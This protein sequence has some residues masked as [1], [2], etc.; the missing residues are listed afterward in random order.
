MTLLTW[1]GATDLDAEQR[2]DLSQSDI[3]VVDRAVTSARMFDGKLMLATD[4]GE[5]A[6]DAI[7]PALG[8]KVSSGIAQGLGDRGDGNDY[9]YVDE[10]QRAEVPAFY[11]IGDVVAGLNQISRTTGQAA[12]A[13]TAL[14]NDLFA[15]SSL[16]R[17]TALQR[18]YDEVCL[19]RTGA[20]KIR[21]ASTGR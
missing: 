21:A 1:D 10:H 11:A 16:V 5:L 17:P 19:P 18:P 6:F 2:A 12:T 3:T 15:G 4:G 7:Y 13:A 14:R 8:A 9:L 20:D